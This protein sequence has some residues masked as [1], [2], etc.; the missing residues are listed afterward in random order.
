MAVNSSQEAS[1]LTIN[2]RARWEEGFLANLQAADEGI[3]LPGSYQYRME[4]TIA[5]NGIAPGL[6]A[7]DV[8][9][10]PCRLLYL[11]DA[12]TRIVYTYDPYQDFA[13][14]LDHTASLFQAPMRLTYSP[15]YLYVLEQGESGS[16][17][18]QTAEVNGQWLWDAGPT[19]D[20]AGG[21]PSGKKPLKAAEIAA[22]P[23]GE[24]Y[25]LDVEQKFIFRLSESGRITGGFG[26]AELSGRGPAAI[27]VS[28]DGLVFVLE[29]EL[30]QVTVFKE[31]QKIRDFQVE[32][33]TFP[34]CIG[35]DRDGILYVGDGGTP[36]EDTEENR[37]IHVYDAEGRRLDR[38]PPYR[39]AAHRIAFD[40]QSTMYVLNKQANSL[41]MLT[42]ERTLQKSPGAP[43][44][45]G[46]YFSKA[47]DSVK[48]HTL[49]HELRMQADLPPGT[50]M[51]VSY[52]ASDDKSF[53]IQGKMR[54]LGS[55]ITST[56][57]AA[58][59]KLG[60]LE[61][62]PWSE[63]MLN[64]KDALFPNAAGRYLWLKIRLIGSGA[65]SPVV[66]AVT[67]FF[68]RQSYL[69]YLP[70]IYQEDEAGRSFL[71]RYLSLFE[72]FLTDSETTIDQI[73][74]W[75][76]ADA[77][78]GEF[79]RWLSSWLAIAY[80]ENWPE[81]KLRQLVRRVPDLY[82]KRGTREGLQAMIELFTGRKPFIVE[83]FQLDS[84]EDEEVA[85]LLRRLYGSDPY[86]FCV[87]LQPQSLSSDEY[88]AVRRIV[89][90]EKPAHTA[91][92]ITLLQPY[93]YL[94]HHTYLEINSVL[95]RPSSR[96]GDG[97]I[98]RDS[99]L[100]DRDFAG[101]VRS[102][103]KLERDTVLS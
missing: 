69:R 18:V 21:F 86:G 65:L 50:Q 99:V 68:P 59:V 93:I 73:A 48:M 58:E 90:E 60:A 66:Q 29:S 53:R 55:Y 91:A 71:E 11:L 61:Q 6:E 13:E 5:L 1:F 44:S 12:T 96:L 40:H 8:I 25:A 47:F 43:L 103:A 92:G 42:R 19:R 89:E 67:A 72:R 97:V 26:S 20:A 56:A 23:Q 85:R 75:F 22:G 74:R 9:S 94:D 83:H 101:H 88:A 51:E 64:P 81:D 24:V 46:V 4:R 95:A 49:W 38:S 100:S 33:P 36:G 102:K 57:T 27:A 2:H 98:Q 31:G 39:G 17:V 80:D 34:S 41:S 77:V 79:L 52:L 16:K 10:G 30:R 45:E 84:V 63:P 54:D 15:R 87:L 82:R 62:L 78:S 37:F 3:R 76:D 70:A 35:M 14:I 32:G 7:E 28:P